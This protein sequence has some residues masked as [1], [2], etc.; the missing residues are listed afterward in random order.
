LLS[1][2]RGFGASLDRRILAIYEIMS[3]ST[4]T[5][6]VVTEL[7]VIRF[8][9]NLIDGELLKEFLIVRES[10]TREGEGCA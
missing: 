2:E 1:F 5:E 10:M 3:S 8:E 9:V 4:N 6:V 7:G